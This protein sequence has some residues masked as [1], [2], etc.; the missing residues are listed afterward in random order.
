MKI[1][2]IGGGISGC[3]TYLS[4]KKH[5][6]AA[7]IHSITIYEAYST[8]HSPDPPSTTNSNDA[9]NT[10]A[11]KTPIIGGGL[12]LA[13]NGLR[14]LSRLDPSQSLIQDIVRSGYAISTMSLKTKSGR[15]LADLD[16]N[17]DAGPIPEVFLSQSDSHEESHDGSIGMKM[18]MIASSR[19]G[20]WGCLRDRVPDEDVVTK[21]VEDVIPR[22]D[23]LNIFQFEDGGE[24]EVDLVIGADGLRSVTRRGMFRT[25]TEDGEERYEYGPHYEGLIGVGGFTPLPASLKTHLKPGTMS[26][27]FSGNGFFGYFPSSS[28]SE[29]P[30]STSPYT[31]TPPGETLSW[32]STYA[33][34]SP[35]PTPSDISLP[36]IT[37][38]LKSRHANWTDPII[39]S[40]LATL[41]VENIYPTWTSPVLETWE[42]HGVIL[43]GDAAHAL[44][45]TS[46]QGASQGMEDGEALGMF[47]VHSITQGREE[48]EDAEEI[49][50][51]E[52]D[53]L[54]T[55][56]TITRAAKRYIEIRKPH[57]E[58]ILNE[59]KRMQN[60]KRDVGWVGEM[61][62]YAVLWI[63]G[64]FP[65][66]LSRKSRS[67]IN[68]NVADEA[69]KVMSKR[70]QS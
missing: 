15:V 6:P 26:L 58:V 69:K 37:A 48:R 62:M 14:V 8:P 32:W 49:E 23:G 70:Q 36:T 17:S 1:A 61:V 24:V 63:M 39:Q 54:R 41:T 7:C 27:L 2:I 11:T 46:A 29:H 33:W 45:S 18:N 43:V 9:E 52:E 21:R 50:E 4:L 44:P 40:I 31:I 67:I 59:A 20:L 47:L 55:K 22:P 16:S 35:P 5:L 10:T 34:P 38:D 19:H 66:I 3:T 68:Y 60:N 42:K 56:R 64:F 51:A 65:S 12:G 25:F 30:T 13:P 53:I 28:S 57:V